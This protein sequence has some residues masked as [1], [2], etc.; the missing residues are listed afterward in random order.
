M[1]FTDVKLGVAATKATAKKSVQVIA[2]ASASAGTGKSEFAFNM[3]VSL[4]GIGQ[5]AVLL[6]ADFA[7]TEIERRF[8]DLDEET[9]QGDSAGGYSSLK[10]ELVLSGTVQLARNNPG[11]LM[12]SEP[13]LLE[14]VSL[15]RAFS[16]H[17]ENMSHLIIDTSSKYSICTATLC[18][19]ATQLII[20]VTG[21]PVASQ[22]CVSLIKRLY[23]E[24][25]I[26]RFRIVASRVGSSGEAERIF[27]HVIKLLE[28]SHNIVVTYEGFIPEDSAVSQPESMYRGLWAAFPRSRASMAIRRM[29]ENVCAWPLPETPGGQIEFFVE[30]LI[31]YKN[32][33][34][35]VTS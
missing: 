10:S 5:K 30:R 24:N 34:M 9:L 21:A 28:Y 35:E 12:S 29:A 33:E 14:C 32:T 2:I 23:H 31:D 16:S 26:R 20:L 25:G 27:G 1:Q 7:N 17:E 11:H 22:E 13:D 8:F 15:I 19:A 4:A 18:A 6:N 3:A